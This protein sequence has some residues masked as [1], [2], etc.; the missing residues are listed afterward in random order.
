MAGSPSSATDI[1]EVL[2]S[3]FM[4]SATQV[5]GQIRLRLDVAATRIASTSGSVAASSAPM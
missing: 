1:C 2:G 5:A 3:V 4:S